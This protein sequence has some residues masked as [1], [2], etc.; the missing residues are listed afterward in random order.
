V[1]GYPRQAVY[2]RLLIN[3]LPLESHPVNLLPLCV[4]CLVSRSPGQAPCGAKS[5]AGLNR[6]AAK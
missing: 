5:R 4:Q 3:W 1:R 6:S 2:T